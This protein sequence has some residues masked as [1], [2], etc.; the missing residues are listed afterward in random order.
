MTSTNASQ[1]W[2]SISNN[3]QN[4]PSEIRS[5]LQE[6]RKHTTEISNDVQALSHELHSSKLEIFGAIGGMKSWCKE[7]GE[8]QGLQIEFKS[9]DAQISLPHR[10]SDFAC[11]GFYRKPCTMQPSTAGRNGLKCNS[12]QTRVRF[13]SSSLI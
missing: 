13:I 3:S 10:K 8:R 5:R 4:D 9:P 6:L 7:F 1:C 11:F 12:G 2:H